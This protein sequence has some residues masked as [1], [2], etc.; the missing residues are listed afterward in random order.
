[1]FGNYKSSCQVEFHWTLYK[2][3]LTDGAICFDIVNMSQHTEKT[4]A[5][6]YHRSNN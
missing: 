2:M 5:E 4:P 3:R 1:M 6:F